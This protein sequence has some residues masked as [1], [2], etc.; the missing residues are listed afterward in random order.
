[1]EYLIKTIY[2]SNILYVVL[3][4]IDDFNYCN[5]G[6]ENVISHVNASV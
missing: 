2:T 1:M 6:F 4:R 3:N 5:G